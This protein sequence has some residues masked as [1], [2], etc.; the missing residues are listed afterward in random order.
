MSDITELDLSKPN[1]HLNEPLFPGLSWT[2]RD[3]SI[4]SAYLSEQ[5]ISY[6]EDGDSHFENSVMDRLCEML[7]EC[8]KIYAD[9]AYAKEYDERLKL[10]KQMRAKEKK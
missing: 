1:S 6:I 10:R 3:F 8:S 7:D 9:S 5:L 2:A 4:L